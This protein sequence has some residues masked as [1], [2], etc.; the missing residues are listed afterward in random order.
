M[1][2]I[3]I[4]WASVEAMAQLTV[5]CAECG[6]HGHLSRRNQELLDPGGR[7][8]HHVIPAEC[9]VL[10]ALLVGATRM[11]DWLEWDTADDDDFLPSPSI[12]ADQSASDLMQK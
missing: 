9:P 12:V 1:S 10:R 8:K 11:L 2:V 4:G 5:T 7:C 6:L 3:N